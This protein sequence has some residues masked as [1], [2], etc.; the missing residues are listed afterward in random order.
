[1]PFS[2]LAEQ[3]DFLGGS[4]VDQLAR[5]LSILSAKPKDRETVIRAA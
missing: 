5:A 1:L 4:D 2:P 3:R